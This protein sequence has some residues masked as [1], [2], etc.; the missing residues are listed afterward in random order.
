M[1][2]RFNLNLPL[3][4]RICSWGALLG[5]FLLLSGC[6]T[7]KQRISIESE[8]RDAFVYVNGKF[9]G[10]SPVDVR[11]NRQVPHRVEIRKAGF[12]SE[13]I[14]LYPSYKEGKEPEVVFGPFRDSGLYRVLEPNPVILSLLYEGLTTAPAILT[15]E[16]ASRY[17]S[18]IEAEVQS[19]EMTGDEAAVAEAQVLK[20]VPEE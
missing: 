19:G 9:I 4:G 20:R 13:E 2:T 6:G 18:E 1:S 5:I 16:E 3:S 11:L 12:V 8:P 10:N 7:S 17:L 15:P 14:T